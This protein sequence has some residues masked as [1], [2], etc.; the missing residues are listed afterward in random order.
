MPPLTVDEFKNA[1]PQQMQKLVSQE[2]MDDVNSC[3]TDPEHLDNFRENLLT[4]T[5]VLQTGKY[6]ME[7]YINAVRY[8]GFKIMGFTNHDS[9]M[10]TFP[11]KYAR[12]VANKVSKK[13][14]S[15]YVAAFNKGKM[16]HMILAQA[17]VPSHILNAHL[18]Q[19]AL[20][21]QAM[22]MSD[23]E[24]SP[25]VRVDAANS[26]LTHLKAPDVPKVEIEVSHNQGS[27][28]D[29]YEL[30]FKRMVQ[31]QK[32]LIEAGGDLLTITNASIKKD[33]ALIEMEPIK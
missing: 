24:V 9:Y 1:L 7:H 26:L 30:V 31:E 6:K 23:V 4:F 29:D 28:I 22:I 19:K 11:A 5:S 17:M 2:I 8:C 20:N 13:D 25:K 15:S 18:F 10:H 33:P 12:F 21:I 32:K 16:V 14:I 27:I 3:L